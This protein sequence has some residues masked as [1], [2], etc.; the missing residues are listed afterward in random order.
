M[1]KVIIPVNRQLSIDGSLDQA[2]FFKKSDGS[3]V[4]RKEM[5]K[6]SAAITA[7]WVEKESH[8]LFTI[9]EDL[10]LAEFQ[11]IHDAL[12]SLSEVLKTSI[13]DSQAFM[14]YLE[15]GETAFLIKR[16]HR[17]KDFL[18]RARHRSLKGQKVEVREV[19]GILLEYTEE[20][21]SPH[22]EVKECVILTTFGEQKVTGKNLQIEPTG[23]F[24]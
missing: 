9:P 11:M 10:E 20:E 1:L 13:D 12:S 19:R 22:F 21:S 3:Y 24:I 5:G 14:G 16:W 18:L 17:W 8:L 6:G 7:V 4:F 2:G 23:E 15:N